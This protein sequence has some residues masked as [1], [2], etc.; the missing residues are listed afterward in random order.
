[1]LT[2]YTETQKKRIANNII[3]ACYDINKLSKQAYNYLNLCSGFIAHYNHAGF[4][5]HYMHYSLVRDLAANAKMNQWRNFTP[6]DQHYDYYMSKRDI[7]NMIL[8]GLAAREFVQDHFTF[9]SI[10]GHA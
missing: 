6:S 10:P 1:M 9:I 4:I 2:P 3:K 8:G 7:Y 5:D